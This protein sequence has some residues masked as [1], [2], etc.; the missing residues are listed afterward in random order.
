MSSQIE[1]F[2]KLEEKN[3]LAELGGGQDRI[4]RQHQATVQQLLV[5]VDGRGR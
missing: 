4:D 2:K 1:K 5:Q 3:R